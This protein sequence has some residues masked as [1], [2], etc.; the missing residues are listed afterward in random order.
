MAHLFKPSSV[1]KTSASEA[2]TPEASQG[3]DRMISYLINTKNIEKEVRP[4]K[5]MQTQMFQS[6]RQLKEEKMQNV[7]SF[8]KSSGKGMENS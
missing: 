5:K 2:T 7:K 6:Q 1:A 4:K 8:M 3:K